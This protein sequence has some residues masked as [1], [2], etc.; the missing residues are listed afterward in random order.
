MGG[1]HVSLDRMSAEVA[2]MLDAPEVKDSLARLG[3][4]NAYLN[5]EQ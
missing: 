4:D 5:S 2:K 1:F 3:L